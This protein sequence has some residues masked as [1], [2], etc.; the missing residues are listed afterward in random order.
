[1]ASIGLLFAADLAGAIP[2]TKPINV[3]TKKDT[4][5]ELKDKMVSIPVEISRI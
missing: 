2:K 5:I 1:M 4:N 3:A